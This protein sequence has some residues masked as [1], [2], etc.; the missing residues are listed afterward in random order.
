MGKGFD[1]QGRVSTLWIMLLTLASVATTLALGC[2]MPFEALATVAAM[3]L[4]RRDGFILLGL[5]W[6][7]NQAI[8]FG[9][10]GYPHDI[11][12]L[13]WGVGL[14]TAAI[15]AGL[16]AY[17]VAGR[18]IGASAPVRIIGIYVAAFVALKAVVLAWALVLGGV[19]IT[20]SPT[21][22]A[23]QFATNAAILLGLLALYH[24]LVRI[25]LPRPAMRLVAA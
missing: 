15:G 2:A 21:Y 14:G 12:T 5:G 23:Q 10:L 20:L 9:I 8:G 17:F 1:R 6:A 19:S 25:G 11:R 7:I 13:A 24:G 18:T 3:Y 22:S 4:Y 16:G